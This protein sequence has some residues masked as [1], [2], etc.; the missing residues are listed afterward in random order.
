MLKNK[1]VFWITFVA[2][3]SASLTVVL[4]S[5]RQEN[6]SYEAMA[7]AFENKKMN[8][9][10]SVDQWQ[11]G[12]AYFDS[13]LSVNN[14]TLGA[15]K[16]LLWD[17]WNIEFAGAGAEAV[18]KESVLPLR[19]LQN[20][21]SGCM[22]L[23]W[24]AM[25]VAEAR[26]VPLEVVLLPGHVFLR[27]GSRENGFY[28]NMEP[29]REGFSYSDDEYREKYKDGTWT[30]L[31]FKPLTCR[32]FVGL[33]AFNMGNYFLD[34]NPRQALTWYRMAEDFFSEYPGISVNQKIAKSRLPDHL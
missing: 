30:G 4:W 31:E 20:K 11:R 28:V 13:S 5:G 12:L 8:C 6:E 34:S 3:I 9:L 1:K 15:L 2:L 27:Y 32:H 24:L 25:M 21:K 7:C 14:D 19:V 33:A 17:F 16:S 10:D 22:G 29:N 23:S 26:N 18:S